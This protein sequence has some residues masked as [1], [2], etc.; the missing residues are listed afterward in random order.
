MLLITDHEPRHAYGIRAEFWN[1]W[2]SDA[3]ARMDRLDAWEPLGAT[4]GE[5]YMRGTACRY[6]PRTGYAWAR[7]VAA[8]RR[9]AFP[10]VD[11]ARYGL[12]ILRDGL[13]EVRAVRKGAPPP[14]PWSATWR[15]VTD[16][17][18]RYHA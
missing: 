5:E 4:K 9:E 10:R 18:A 13:E 11:G 16:E 17:A 6:V 12:V 14:K 15:R 2:Q 1:D 7:P 8:A 3:G